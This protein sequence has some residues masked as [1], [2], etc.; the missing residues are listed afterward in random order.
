MLPVVLLLA[1]FTLNQWSRQ[2]IFYVVDFNRAPSEEAARLFMNLDIGFDQAQY[3]VL[4]SVGFAVL[5]AV[6]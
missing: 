1:I 3:G 5:F 2:I 4:A 6:T